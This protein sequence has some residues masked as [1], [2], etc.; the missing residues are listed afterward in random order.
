MVIHCFSLEGGILGKG[1]AKDGTIDVII[2]FHGSRRSTVARHTSALSSMEQGE[3][4]EEMR[5]AGGL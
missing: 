5:G 3:E 2:Y 1:K 4:K